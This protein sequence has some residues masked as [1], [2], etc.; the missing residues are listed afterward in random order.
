MSTQ[1]TVENRLLALEKAIL[2]DQLQTNILVVNPDGTIGAL[3]TGH[4][5][6]QGIDLTEGPSLTFVPTSAVDW[7]DTG[8]TVRSFLQ[9][10]R[11]APDH[12]LSMVSA[13]DGI[14]IAAISATA[15]PAGGLGFSAITFTLTDA[16]GGNQQGTIMR[17]DGSSAFFQIA[18][19]GPLSEAASL[20]FGAAHAIGW[21][22]GGGVLREFVQGYVVG[23]GHVL[24]LVSQQG[25]TDSATLRTVS[26]SGGASA[27]S[28]AQAVVEDSTN[29]T[30]L[31]ADILRS[32]GRSSFLQGGLSTPPV[33]TNPARALG[34][35]YTPNA[36]HPT[37]VIANFF[38]VGTGPAS[39]AQAQ[40][41]V[42]GA[43]VANLFASTAAAGA[44]TEVTIPA[45]FLVPA[46]G[47]YELVAVTGSVALDTAV[48]VIEIRL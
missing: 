1:L 12:L 5:I 8:G 20:A 23:S 45:T 13:P 9:G 6:A 3:L 27:N 22:D 4:L 26:V 46:G 48:G 7:L 41:L 11:I 33:F 40:V 17:S 39:G 29:A 36:L 35:V 16:G 44:T 28:A 24:E 2:A 19:A 21:Y 37:L 47:T 15:R 14:D 43:A 38:L 34:T 18:K 32:D 10:Y 30:I 42:N 31:T 25:V